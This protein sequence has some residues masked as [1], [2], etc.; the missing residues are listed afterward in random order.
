M[1]GGER[2]WLMLV[3]ERGG[4]YIVIERASN[5]ATTEKFVIC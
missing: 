3:R 1:F 2:K 5:A 4:N